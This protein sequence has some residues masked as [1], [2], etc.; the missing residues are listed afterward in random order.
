MEKFQI[1]EDL[2]KCPFCSAPEIEEQPQGGLHAYN[3][4]YTCGT[5]IIVPIG[6]DNVVI[7]KNCLNEE[8]TE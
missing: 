8:I 7:E 3:L 6:F 2:S 5:E 4:I 1:I